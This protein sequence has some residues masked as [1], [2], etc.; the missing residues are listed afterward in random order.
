MKQEKGDKKSSKKILIIFVV[1]LLL[2][3]V[4]AS[5]WWWLTQRDKDNNGD[6]VGQGGNHI[7]KVYSKLTG[8]E[9][10][11]ESVNSAP[12]FCVQIPNGST[13]GARPQAGLTQAG[14]VF[15]AIAE[16]G[17]T[18]FAAVFQVPTTG[19]IGPI[20]S[21]RPYYLDWDTP[22]DCT[23]VHDGGSHE[24]LTAIAQGGQRNLDEDFRYMWKV[25]DSS[26]LWNNVF[27][28]PSKL[29][30]FNDSKGYITSSP[31]TFPRLTPEEVEADRLIPECTKNEAGE[32]I[33]PA[34]SN[35]IF[36]NQIQASFTGIHDYNIQYTYDAT[37]NRYLRSYTQGGA[38]M[39]YDCPAGVT[40]FA[41]C[42]A[43]VQVAPSSVVLMRVQES[44]MSDGYHENIATISTGSA[45]IFQNGKLIEGTWRKTAQNHQ[46]SFLNAAGEEIAFT[47]G[48]IW[49]SAIPQFGNISWE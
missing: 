4:G 28:S 36:V 47:P 3:V 8:L 46:I 40:E 26:R 1:I 22:F 31:K 43:P 33:E 5:V 7:E 49:I 16:T 20:R 25:N 35:D 39:T 41:N 24:A 37:T 15:E 38:H 17:I 12:T 30:E 44:T 21:L 2:V 13:D 32:C 48:Q 14:V 11:D 29:Q 6:G 42:G 19:I 23:V 18:R 9:V 45:Y 10:I 34:E 27:T